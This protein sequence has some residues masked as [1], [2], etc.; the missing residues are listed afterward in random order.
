MAAESPE[1]EICGFLLGD[2][3]IVPARNIA[4]GD[5]EFELDHET[6]IRVYQ[7]TGGT[8]RAVY[9]SHPSGCE[10]PSWEDVRN[11][12]P[13]LNIIIVTLADCVEWVV[14]DDKSSVTRSTRMAGQVCRPAAVG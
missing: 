4:S 12:P 14:A 7:Q 13:G 1:R 8:I 10:Y 6:T 2:D 9:H 3:T 11:C 5:S